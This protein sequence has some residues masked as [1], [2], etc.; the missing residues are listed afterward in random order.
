MSYGDQT[1]PAYNAQ[2]EYA[3]ISAP[4]KP[5]GQGD[6]AAAPLMNNQTLGNYSYY[7]PPA[8]YYAMTS[9]P[10]PYYAMTS[11]PASYYAMASTPA[12]YSTTMPSVYNPSYTSTVPYYNPTLHLEKYPKAPETYNDAS[13]VPLAS[14]YNLMTPAPYVSPP[15]LSR[16]VQYVPALE[17]SSGLYGTG[18]VGYAGYNKPPEVVYPA[19]SSDGPKQYWP[20]MLV[21]ASAGSLLP[22]EYNS[23]PPQ[24]TIQY[25]NGKYSRRKSTGR[26]VFP[27]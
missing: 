25:D 7:Q 5:A 4:Y 22:V 16:A 26:A 20:S 13:S 3:T 17:V 12:P 14:Y 21:Y 23:Y 15:S 24:E 8:P 10:A 6:Y 11:T 18:D 27:R 2:P 19:D 1:K 9:T